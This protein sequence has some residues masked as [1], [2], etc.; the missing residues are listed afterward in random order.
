M[1]DLTQQIYSNDYAD[2]LVRTYFLEQEIFLNFFSEAG[3]LPITSQYSSVFLPRAKLSEDLFSFAPYDT[4]P[5]LFTLLDTQ[6]LEASGILTVRQ[7]PVLN[8][9]GKNTLIGFVDTGINYTHPAFSTT[10]GQTRILRI[11]DQTD[12]SGTSP[13]AFP[14]GS[15]Y[16]NQQ[17]QEALDSQDPYELVP[18][19][20]PEGHG[21]FLAGIAAGTPD[22][23]QDFSGAAPGADIL[24]VKLKQ[25]KPYLKDYFHIPS[26]AAA[27]QENDIMA[28]ITYLI[29]T[30]R[31]L[32]RP[33]AL[34]IALGSNQGGHTGT[35]PLSSTLSQLS[36][37]Q[38][39]APVIGCGNES[40][41]G[42]HYLGTVP[43]DSEMQNV[44]ILVPK[45]SPGFTMELWGDAPDLFSVGFLSPVGEQI[46]RIPARLG[47]SERISFVL[48]RTVIDIH[49]D[50]IQTTSGSQLIT[51]RFTDP[52]PGI[53]NLQVFSSRKN[54]D[55][56]IW[57]PITGFTDPD[58]RFLSPDPY[59]TLTLPSSAEFAISVSAYDSSSQSLFIHSGRGF[60]RRSVIKPDI[61]SPG[62]NITGPSINNSYSQRTGS[63]MA[64]ALCSGTAALLLEW[65]LNRPIPVFFSGN[66]V[67][68]Y[69]IRGAVRNPDLVY[70]NRE[71]GY[72]TMNIYETFLSLTSG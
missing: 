38:G 47:E 37:L 41:M 69:L 21:T 52:T 11:W 72:G 30:A 61:C 27:Y 28:G 60:T 71:W 56:H 26:S 12:T 5:K 54:R 23:S 68:I 35:L 46:S 1:S 3:T 66:E 14:Y 53:W 4:I 34:C 64:A 44:E 9:T 33:I 51:F 6:A 49:Y 2:F 22:A 50:L 31:Q 62:V 39:V 36:E 29:E 7:Q 59:T 43:L 55:F 16:T 10:T 67:R 8:L 70:P 40:G 18:T 25:A 42:H 65:G 57:L 15:E 63:S 17:I 20:D 58:V 19:R 48:E 13:S 45:N 32:A 24:V